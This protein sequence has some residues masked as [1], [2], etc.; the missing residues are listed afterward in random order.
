M[1]ANGCFLLVALGAGVPAAAWGAGDR[2]PAMPSHDASVVY[3][4]EPAGQP[5]QSVRV[6]FGRGGEMLRVDGPGGEG[7]TLLDRRTGDLTVVM[8][9]Q[10]VYMVVPSKGPVHDPFLLGDDMTYARTGSRQ[11]I[12]GETCDDWRV[13]T[14]KG[15][16]TACVTPDG[17]L[18]AASGP[19]AAGVSGRITAESVS[20][21]PLPASVFAP[22]AGFTRIAHPAGQP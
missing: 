17:L 12:A 13:G 8:N 21:A 15:P 9:A 4:V 5:A 18:L 2:P 22:P 3:R 20:R 1:K 19:D 6:A 11:T 14:P 16:G 10:R 7:D